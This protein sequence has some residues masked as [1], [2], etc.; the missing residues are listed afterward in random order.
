MRFDELDLEPE[1]LE[2]V[3]AMNFRETTPI[4]Q[5]TIPTVL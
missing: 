4:H 3:D 5:L 2:G 1:V